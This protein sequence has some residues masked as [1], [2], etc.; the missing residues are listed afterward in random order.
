MSDAELRQEAARLDPDDAAGIL[1]WSR[2]AERAYGPEG[3][4]RI[5]V[6]LW[7]PA[8][9]ELLVAPAPSVKKAKVWRRGR[10]W[11]LGDWVPA[12]LHLI[13]PSPRNYEPGRAQAGDAHLRC[14]RGGLPVP[15]ESWRWGW[16]TCRICQGIPV[17]IRHARLRALKGRWWELDATAEDRDAA[18]R[19]A[20]GRLRHEAQS[21]VR[22]RETRS[23]ADVQRGQQGLF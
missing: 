5:R 16:P 20:I 22:H 15:R 8:P 6:D 2:R 13:E 4:M 12:P 18:D 7:L 10:P 1:A 17:L 3:A 14:S 19:H 9:G 23:Y 11:E 21:L